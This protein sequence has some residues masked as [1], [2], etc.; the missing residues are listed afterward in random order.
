MGVFSRFHTGLKLTSESVK[1]LHQHP[2]LLIFPFCAASSSIA[3]SV[4]IFFLMATASLFGGVRGWVA[5]FFVYLSVAASVS[6]FTA[7]L[8][9][10]TAARLRGE[11]PP[12]RQSIMAAWKKRSPVFLWAAIAASVGLVLRWFTQSDSALTRVV[13]SA[14]M[15]GW[16]AMTFFVLPV[17]VF[18]KR[19][20]R[21]LFARSLSLFRNT[22]GEVT[23][24]GLGI[25]LVHVLFATGLVSS[26]VLLTAALT[27]VVTLPSGVYVWGIVG[28]ILLS[29][30]FGK[31]VTAITKTVVYL[32]VHAELTPTQFPAATALVT[33]THKSTETR[34]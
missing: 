20:T 16:I 13:G 18:E 17:I 32:H 15:L 7:A 8:V 31:T 33:D 21:Q 10:A 34:H 24:V 3:L 30:L 23:S 2:R 5:L 19:P 26:I 25:S 9:H 11:V 28:A 29:Y 22:W 14:F 6:F 1:L 12:L 27:T 4:T